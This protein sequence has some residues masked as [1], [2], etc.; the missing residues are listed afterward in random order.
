MHPSNPSRFS[1]GTHHSDDD[2]Y[3]SRNPRLTVPWVDLQRTGSESSLDPDEVSGAAPRS[4]AGGRSPLTDTRLFLIDTTS[5]EL[6]IVS[7]TEGFLATF[8]YPPTELQSLTLMQLMGPETDAGVLERMRRAIA[9][10]QPFSEPWLAYRKNGTAFWHHLHLFP[11]CHP[12]EPSRYYI[13]LQTPYSQSLPTSLP[14]PNELILNSAGEGIYGLDLGGHIMFVNPAAARMLGWSVQELLG[15]SIHQVLQPA[16]PCEDE[17]A[18]CCLGNLTDEQPQHV[19]HEWFLRRDGSRFRVEYTSTPIAHSG[20]V[21]GTVVVFQDITERQAQED[22]LRESEERYALAAQGANDGIWDWNVKTGKIYFSPRWRGILGLQEQDVLDCLEHWFDWIHPDDRQGFQRDLEAHLRG[23]SAHFEHEHRMRD[24]AGNDHWV[25]TRGLAVRDD[26]GNPS[27]LAGSLTDI[28]HRKQVEAQLLHDALHDAL[29][30]LPNRMLLMERLQHIVDMAQRNPT[31]RYAVLFLDIDRFKV[32]NDSLGHLQGD[33][34]LQAIAH[35]LNTCIRPGDTVARLGGDE[36]VI[37]LEHIRDINSAL[38]VAERVQAALAQP[39][40]LKPQEVFVTASIGVA[41]GNDGYHQAADLLRDADTAM[42]RAKSQGRARYEVF[43]PGMHQQAVALLML[44]N[45]LRRGLER[46]EFA[47][48][49]QPIIALPDARLA[50]FEALLRWHHP[51]RGSIPP[52]EFIPVAEETELITPL[53]N[54][55]MLE[56]CRCMTSW[57]KRFLNAR[58]LTI[59]VNLSGKHFDQNFV[60]DLKHTLSETGLPAATLNLEITESLLMDNAD[61]AVSLLNQ[62]KDLG[63]RLSIDDFGTGYSSLSYLHRFPIDILKVDRAFISAVDQDPEAVAIVRTIMT[64]AWNLGIDVVAEGVETTKQLA[65][66]LALK[67][68][69]AQGFYYSKPLSESDIEAMLS[70]SCLPEANRYQIH[71]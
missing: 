50:G 71:G 49:Y 38:I 15:Q 8:G 29:T 35:R 5:A 45:D 40:P 60:H 54:W 7:A 43:N 19:D 12:T 36:F 58:S 34:L 1:Q 3:P 11:L 64:L 37:L 39:I 52:G 42:Y 17:I 65:Q 66:V 9:Q 22:A 33:C 53:E 32:I 55:A 2:H 21:V 30:G 31:Y 14:H 20:E 70:G 25:L 59:H 46:Q 28:T 62:L 16:L 69:M 44:E 47:L 68:D 56:A 6:R 24:R 51:S 61:S 4:E 10:N 13:A 63:V 27:R 18:C 67:C 41:L 57:Q 23:D 48:H 26:D